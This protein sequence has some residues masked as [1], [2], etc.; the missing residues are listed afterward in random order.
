MSS[1]V[2]F[3]IDRH[4]RQ[5]GDRVTFNTEARE[6]F[7]AFATSAEASWTRNFRDLGGAVTRMC[8]AASGGR[9]TTE[10]VDDEIARLRATWCPPDSGAGSPLANVLG[11]T[12]L[13]ELDLF[14]RVQLEAIMQVA[15]ECRTLSEA[16]RMLFARSRARKSSANDADRLRKYLARFALSWEELRA[17]FASLSG[18]S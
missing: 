9:I 14:D 18:K 8:T 5:T 11:A 1:D 15:A 13:A 12:R 10:I 17:P 2:A 6:R 4:A 3:E 7:L 16:G